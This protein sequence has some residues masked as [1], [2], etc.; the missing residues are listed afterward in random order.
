MRKT[1]GHT[2]CA[3]T[4][5][6]LSASPGANNSSS[7]ATRK[8]SWISAETSDF[9]YPNRIGRPTRGPATNLSTLTN[10]GNSSNSASCSNSLS[11]QLKRNEDAAKLTKYIDDNIIGKNSAF[12][13][14]FGRRKVVFCDYFASGRSLQFIEDYILRE[15]LPCYG[16]T[17]STTTIT[18]IQ[19]SLFRQEARD[20]IK[21]AVNASEDDAVIFVGHGCS[22]AVRKLVNALELIEAPIVF[23]GACEHQ[24]NLQIWQEIGAKIIRIAETKQN[25]L[26]L[27]DLEDQLRFHQNQTKPLIGCFAATSS[28]TGVLVDDVSATILLHQYGALAFWDYNL[29]APY[30]ELDMNPRVGGGKGVIVEEETGKGSHERLGNN[31]RE[32]T[33]KDAMYF[34]GHKFV[35]GVQTPGIL[36]AKK[37]LFKKSTPCEPEGFFAL[38]QQH[39]KNFE[40]QEEGS[41][42]AVIESVRAG[43]VMQLKETVTAANILARQEKITKQFLQHIRTIP[44]VILL[45]N[46]SP[47]LKRIPVFSF[48]VR[49]PRSTFLHHNFVVAILNDVF[50]IQ[51]RGGCPCSAPYAQDLLGIDDALATQYESIILEDRRLNSL[52]LSMES[53]HL[54]LLRPGFTR[55]SLPYFISDGELAFIMEAVK[56]VATEG[57]KLL[58]QYVVDLNS[59]EWRHHTHSTIKERKWLGNIRYTDGKMT[60]NERRISGPAQC[61]Q[62]YSECLQT[63]RNLFNRARRMANRNTYQDQGIQ[64][65]SRAEKLRWFMLQQEAQDILTSNSQNIKHNVPFNPIGFAGSKRV[66]ESPT[67]RGVGQYDTFTVTT[68]ASN[69]GSPRHFSLPAIDDHRI[70]TCSSPVPYFVQEVQTAPFFYPSV[71]FT[72]HHGPVNFSVGDPVT[73]AA[74]ISPAPQNPI[75]IHRERCFSLGAPNVS[76]PVLSPQTRI[77]LGMARPRYCTYNSQTDFQSLDSSNDTATSPTHSLQN[78]L[79]TSFEYNQRSS[80]S[81]APPD[82]HTYL[83][84]ITKELATNIKS[85]IREV[86]NTVEDCLENTDSVDMI[87]AFDKHGSGSEDGRSDSISANEVAEYLKEVSKEMANEVKYEIRDVVNTVDEYFT[88][89]KR[90]YSRASSSGESD[91]SQTKSD[92]KYTPGSSSE[93]VV[94]IINK[95]NSTTRLTDMTLQDTVADKMSLKTKILSSGVTSLSSQ[96]S[97]I[98]LTFHDHDSLTENRRSHSELTSLTRT[99]PRLERHSEHEDMPD[100]L[101]M[102]VSE[103]QNINLND[104]EESIGLEVFEDQFNVGAVIKSVRTAV[105]EFNMIQANDRVLVCLGAGGDSLCLL[106]SLLEYQ[107][108][109]GKQLNF[110]I[111]VVVVDPDDNGLDPCVLI[112]HLKGLGVHYILDN[113]NPANKGTTSEDTYENMFSFCSSS[114]R[115]RLYATAKTAAYNVLAVGQHFD[116]LIEGFVISM[117]DRAQLRTLKAHYFIREHNLRVIRP[118]IYLHQEMLREY[119]RDKNIPLSLL[120]NHNQ[121]VKTVNEAFEERRKYVRHLV[122]QQSQV[123]SELYSNLR[124]ALRS[125]IGFGDIDANVKRLTDS[126]KQ[127]LSVDDIDAPSTD[128][129]PIT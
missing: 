8:I 55:L 122:K 88:P 104:E 18:S 114:N 34:S 76:P 50:G 56:M 99:K 60:T 82:L 79:S 23:V 74:I 7:A 40:I 61:P 48:M 94:N 57:W 42:A 128:D 101:V 123:Y 103:H 83:T 84:E 54:E 15:V 120:S 36:V 27:D 62:S 24:D 33:F 47:G 39:C 70:M 71:P 129:E 9:C 119:S 65:D 98:N 66:I 17:H 116:D 107:S 26:D 49:H 85:E 87:Y 102:E 75:L 89:E 19:S 125:L 43:L 12:L 91:K 100:G 30:V 105:V 106:H 31:K 112:P 11:V 109:V 46:S 111:G 69:A 63:A 78:V 121:Q 2:S 21:Q 92:R 81:P 35:G 110:T 64:F 93:T 51:A 59:G 6:T 1:Y 4:T 44:E 5:N 32:M 25:H 10:S 22:G 115:R 124:R 45:G 126:V 29:A 14:P 118:F 95:S 73:S 28:V 52:N 97:G 13:G 127:Q 117:F 80:T 58:P 16:N 72:T 68:Q 3:T 37:S 38:H 77:N 90:S 96:D 20:I 67:L 108:T 86:I 41:S 113:Q 53:S